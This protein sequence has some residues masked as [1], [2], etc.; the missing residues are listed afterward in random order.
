[1][2]SKQ[3]LFDRAKK[4]KGLICDIDG[5]LTN[6]EI[7]I[8]N[9]GN[10][11]R[12]FHT[13]DV[14]GIQMLMS[15]GLKLAVI[16]TSGDDVISHRM[17]QMGIDTYF[18][19]QVDK[20]NAYKLI[21]DQLKFKDDEFAYIGDDISDLSLIKKVG[22]GVTVPNAVPAVLEAAHWTTHKEG[23]KGAVREL[24]EFIL[25]SQNKGAKAVERYLA[26]GVKPAKE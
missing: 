5:V 11:M 16:T 19:G 21:Q 2:E 3:S 18:A 20:R 7:Y 25:N 24:C 15:V 8:E 4:I 23:G 14:V 22:L 12:V 26:A 10:E 17:K 6:G 9:N 13:Q 1:M